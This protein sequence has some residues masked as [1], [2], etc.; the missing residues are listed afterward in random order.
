[1]KSQPRRFPATLRRVI[2]GDTVVLSCDLG[3]H[4]WADIDFRLARINCPEI[5]TPKA[6]EAKEF[7]EA[8]L[9]GRTITIETSKCDRYG[10]WI[11]EIISETGR[12]LSDELLLA[13]L[14]ESYPKSKET[15]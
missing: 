12:K 13:G 11:A 4:V 8:W 5:G 2:D 9:D 3:F 14:A 7:T 15:K 6:Q 1:L 10:R